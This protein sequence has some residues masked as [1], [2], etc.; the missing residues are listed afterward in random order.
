MR[1]PIIKKIFA[2]IADFDSEEVNSRTGLTREAGIEPIQVAKFI[3]ECE[4]KFKITIHDEEV[5]NF[6]CL[7]DVSEYIEQRLDSEEIEV[8]EEDIKTDED[9]DAQRESWYYI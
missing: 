2:D 4:K 8:D 9:K 1:Y 6:K 7:N 3:I 5:Y